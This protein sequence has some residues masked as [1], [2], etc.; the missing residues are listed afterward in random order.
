ML[1]DRFVISVGC[2]M[3][4]EK[5]WH[6]ISLEP[7]FEL[8]AWKLVALR[9]NL[10]PFLLHATGDAGARRVLVEKIGTV[11]SGTP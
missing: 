9:T 7:R 5:V 11:A 3:S 8:C 6:I 2:S 4:Y 10:N 1:L